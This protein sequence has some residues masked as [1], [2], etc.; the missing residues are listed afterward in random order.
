MIQ[1]RYFSPSALPSFLFHS[2]LLIFI[3]FSLSSGSA[4]SAEVAKVNQ[5]SIDLEAIVAKEKEAA[6]FFQG[7]RPTRRAIL[8]DLIKRELLVQEAK[9]MGL[10]KD[11]SVQDR[12][13]TVLFNSL[14]EKKLNPEFEAI[15]VT[16]AEAKDYYSKYPEV[17]TSHIFISVPPGAT[18]KQEEEAFARIKE[19]QKKYVSNKDLSFAEIA[20][21]YSEGSAAPMGGDIDY[22]TKEKLDPAYYNAAVKLGSPGKISDV[23]RTSFGYHIIKLTGVKNWDDADRGAVKR[24]VYEEKRTK[25]FEKYVD[26]LKSKASIKVNSALLK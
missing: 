26:Q 8:D 19:I 6:K 5:K 13:D 16:D 17:R 4:W 12:F 15:K 11:P 2:I 3:G 14:I 22:Q 23:V 24:A 9:K 10:E 1:N 7:N 21:K 18:K 25:L 20:Q